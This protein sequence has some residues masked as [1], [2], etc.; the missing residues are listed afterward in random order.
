MTPI[1]LTA[2]TLFIAESDPSHKDRMIGLVL[3]LLKK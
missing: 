3:L 1:A 2:L